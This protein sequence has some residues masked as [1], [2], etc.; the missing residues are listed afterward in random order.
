[1]KRLHLRH[2]EAP[3]PALHHAH[4]GDSRSY[5]IVTAAL[6]AVFAAVLIALSV[7]GG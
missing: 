3:P 6:G 7:I 2:I 5:V 1:M 4:P